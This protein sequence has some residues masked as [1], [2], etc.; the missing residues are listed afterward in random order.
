MEIWKDI[1]GYEGH[2]QASNTGF[3][4]NKS[5]GKV[6]SVCPHSRGY[7]IIVLAKDGKR[8]TH[9]AHRLV[10]KTFHPLSEFIGATVNHIDGNK[11]NNHYL[12]LEWLSQSDNQK[13]AYRIGLQ[14]VS[15]KQKAAAAKQNR[16]NYSK[17]VIQKTLDGV[18]VARYYSASEA[19]RQTGF[20]QTHIGSVCRGKVKTCH[21]FKFEYA[22]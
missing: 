3:I 9:L 21:N 22:A 5:K 19:G 13:H 2:Y 7:A 12:N 16:E 20:C 8:K 18:E 1:P 14:K 4:R 6:F 17:A 15:E 10:A 11:L